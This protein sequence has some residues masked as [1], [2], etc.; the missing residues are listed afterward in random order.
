MR[1]A[2][3]T[4]I[5]LLVVIC[6][7]MLLLGLGASAMNKLAESQQLAI[8]SGAVL[9]ALQQAR[10]HALK[11]RQVTKVYFLD[12]GI[13]HDGGVGEGGAAVTNGPTTIEKFQTPCEAVIVADEAIVA[14]VKLPSGIIWLDDGGT[15]GK[16]PNNTMFQA[17]KNRRGSLVVSFAPAGNAWDNG[18]WNTTAAANIR[19]CS[20]DDQGAVFSGTAN[21][22]K[23][24]IGPKILWSTI[25]LNKMTGIAELVNGRN[26]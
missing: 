17:Y 1:R 22:A 10:A 21:V 14:S 24:A 16:F 11:T 8:G 5:E 15:A 23:T 12:A 20:I 19:V 6:I 9:G 7:A 13:T 4:L 26:E 2:R 3:F 18:V 25:K